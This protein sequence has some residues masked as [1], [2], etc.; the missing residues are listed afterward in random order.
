DQ[1]DVLDRGLVLQDCDRDASGYACRGLECRDS[2]VAYRYVEERELA[3]GIADQVAFKPDK[4]RSSAGVKDN[5]ASD[6]NRHIGYRRATRPG[7]NTSDAPGRNNRD[8]GSAGLTGSHGDGSLTDE[9]A[10][11][12]RHRCAG[13]QSINTGRQSGQ[14]IKA[15]RTNVG[16]V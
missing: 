2:K 4:V 1:R 11:A 8:I 16:L 10:S 12:L 6:L 5:R 15:I 7:Y 3:V 13:A 9:G 14:H